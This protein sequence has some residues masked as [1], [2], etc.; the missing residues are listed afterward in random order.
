M[1]TRALQNST[2]SAEELQALALEVRE[3]ERRVRALEHQTPHPDAAPAPELPIRS[4]EFSYDAIPLAG[5][6]ILGIAG[7]YLLRALS[8]LGTLPR[9]IG[10]S[11]GL[12][13]SAAW[14][15]LAARTPDTRRAA[16]AIRVSTS[17]LIF[18]PLVWEA[19]VRFQTLPPWLAAALLFAF[20]VAAESVSWRKNL[21]TIAAIVPAACAC[22]ALGLLLGTYALAPFTLA[23]LAIAAAVEFAA[24]EDRAAGARWLVAPCADFAVLALTFLMSRKGGLPEGY[25][26]VSIAFAIALQA[27]LLLIYTA[28]SVART[29]LRRLPFGILEIGQTAAAFGLGLGGIV[30]LTG[31]RIPAAVFALAAAAFCDVAASRLTPGRNKTVYSLFGLLLLAAGPWL[32]LSGLPLTIAWSILA[33]AVVSLH[34]HAAILLSLA[35]FGSGVAA[36]SAAQLFGSGA[37]FPTVEALT[38]IAAAS[39]CYWRAPA[40]NRPDYRSVRLALAATLSWTAAGLLSSLPLF[41]GAPTIVLI[42]TAAAL[43]WGGAAKRHRELVWLMYAY[44]TLAGLR[45][46]SRDLPSAKAIEL[47]APL[48]LF[49]AA[50]I[51]LPRILR[52]SSDR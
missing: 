3:L 32:A 22:L 19:A 42:F 14:L 48:L 47:V 44:M 24:V 1:E 50:L 26:P 30:A 13:Y 17:V 9:G 36:A 25:A 29:L 45:I 5:F 28:S 38:L 7:A 16:I 2:A 23:L 8:E 27:S 21:K 49:G 41:P 39:F 43:A 31:A 37:P 12:A 35:L 51:L 20:C 15:W 46:V 10:V 6:A 18:A 11:A 4:L 33:L 34:A 40:L 52:K